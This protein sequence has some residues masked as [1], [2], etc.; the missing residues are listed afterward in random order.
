[1]VA[2]LSLTTPVGAQPDPTVPLAEA[3]RKAIEDVL[4]AGVIGADLPAPQLSDPSRYLDLSSVTRTYR[5]LGEEGGEAQESHVWTALAGE[6]ENPA[7]RYRSGNAEIGTV[8]RESDGSFVLTGIEDLREKA[9]T[10]YEPAEPLLVRGL[11]PGEERQVRMAVTSMT[12]PMS[13][14]CFTKERSMSGTD[15]WEPI[16]S[17]CQDALTIRS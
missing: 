17:P 4:G 2:M 10:R 6:R 5:L 14:H 1:M 9:L 8:E 13:R 16:A 7:W 11:N 3:D 12:R 15:I